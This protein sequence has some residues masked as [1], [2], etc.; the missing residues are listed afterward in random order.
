MALEGPRRSTRRRIVLSDK[1]RNDLPAQP[2]LSRKFLSELEITADSGSTRRHS[3]CSR[4]RVL[5]DKRRNEFEIILSSG[6]V[7]SNSRECEQIV[8]AFPGGLVDTCKGHIMQ[9]SSILN[10]FAVVTTCCPR[11]D[12]YHEGKVDVLARS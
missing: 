12:G 2:A 5:S 9:T 3:G 8:P 7:A 10:T 4:R 11:M 1:R 6:S